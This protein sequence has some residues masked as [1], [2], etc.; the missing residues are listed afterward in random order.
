[1]DPQII[2]IVKYLI[3]ETPFGHLN[4]LIDNLKIIVGIQVIESSEIQNEI[5]NYE[6]EHLKHLKLDDKTIVLSKTTKDS[7]GY[8]HDQ[9]S[10][11]KILVQPLS[12]NIDKIEQ[13]ETD[14]D[15]FRE[16]L[17]KHLQSYIEKGYKAEITSGNGNFLLLFK[18]NSI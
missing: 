2:N 6:M 10:G 12:E 3:K 11:V 5:L 1:M 13:T 8:F 18:L 9:S 17:N 14:N 4:N 7:E 15:S 16:S